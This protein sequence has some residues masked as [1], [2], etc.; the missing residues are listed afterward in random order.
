MIYWNKL[1]IRFPECSFKS[2]DR[3]C[4]NVRERGGSPDIHRAGTG[5]GEAG[6]NKDERRLLIPSVSAT[7]SACDVLRVTVSR[8]A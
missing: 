3:S 4:I 7:S 6:F 2:R 8:G 5:L 1:Q